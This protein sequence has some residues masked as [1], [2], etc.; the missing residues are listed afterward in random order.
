MSKQDLNTA[1]I[2]R[3]FQQMSR[4]TM[5]QSVRRYGLRQVSCFTGLVADSPDG[6]AAEWALR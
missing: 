3:V 4:E 1:Q 2:N 5:A 6:L